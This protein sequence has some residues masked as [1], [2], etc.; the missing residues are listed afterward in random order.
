MKKILS[1][2]LTLSMLCCMAT[3]AFATNVVGT[4]GMNNTVADG[5]ADFNA[6]SATTKVDIKVTTGDIQN[7]YAVDVEFEDIVL[8]VTGSDMTWDVNQLTYVSSGAANMDN[9]SATIK[10]YNYSDLPVYVTPEIINDDP[11]DGIGI[12]STVGARTMVAKATAK[13]GDTPGSATVM[14]MTLNVTSDDWAAVADYYAPLLA[15]DDDG[16]ITAGSLQLTISKD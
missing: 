15:G 2:A 10:V 12:A 7:K 3:T 16:V 5:V 1:L 11:N 4:H 8:A 14:E 6:A 13:N 9:T